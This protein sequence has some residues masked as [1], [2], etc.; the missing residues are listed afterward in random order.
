MASYSL[1]IQSRDRKLLADLLQSPFEAEQ[2]WQLSQ[3]YDLP[4]T[5]VHFVRRRLRKL[6]DAGLVNIFQYATETTGRLNY[7]R[8][9]QQ[10]YT[11]VCGHD[12]ALPPRSHFR[13]VSPALQRHVRYVA[14][15]LVKIRTSAH[16]A[17]LDIPFLLGDNQ[18]RLSSGNETFIPDTVFGLKLKR[19]S[20]QHYLVE[21]DCGTEPVYST[22]QRDSLQ[23]KLSLYYAHEAASENT[24]RVLFLFAEATPRVAHFLRLARELAPDP[25]RH[26]VMAAVLDSVLDHTNPLQW[27]LF[28]DHDQKL[29]S[30]LPCPVPEEAALM[31]SSLLTENW[32]ASAPW[33]R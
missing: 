20:P 25:R 5:D 6:R 18:V 14:S 30:L 3:T 31:Q 8:L 33:F 32:F 4:F 24:Y 1:T 7:Y 16:A 9:S 11:L 23:K 17:G 29:V 22:K 2:L 10:G 19:R 13:A 26:I 28:L 21:L 12:K 27:P 15:L